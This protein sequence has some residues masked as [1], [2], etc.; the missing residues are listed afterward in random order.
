MYVLLLELLIYFLQFLE[1][2]PAVI[3]ALLDIS[4]MILNSLDPFTLQREL[5]SKRVS[6]TSTFYALKIWNVK[7]LNNF[8]MPH[9]KNYIKTPLDLIWFS[10]TTILSLHVNI[11]A[12]TKV[13]LSNL[14]PFFNQNESVYLLPFPKFDDVIS[15]FCCVKWP[16]KLMNERGENSI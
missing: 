5:R 6:T 10:L 1:A 16:K 11:V 8:Q 15:K 9:V 13:V 12:I 7:S 4:P 2:L 14:I 3:S